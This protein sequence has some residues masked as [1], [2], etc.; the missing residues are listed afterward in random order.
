MTRFLVRSASVA[1]L[2]LVVFGASGLFL[3]LLWVFPGPDAQSYEDQMARAAVTVVWIFAAGIF[4]SL[5]LRWFITTFRREL[6]LRIEQ[7]TEP[8]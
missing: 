1:L 2:A 5:F 3:Y 8:K 7:N 4:S 6:N